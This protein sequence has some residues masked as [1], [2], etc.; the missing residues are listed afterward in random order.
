MKNERTFRF[1]LQEPSSGDRVVVDSN[2]QTFSEAV[3]AAYI[4]QKELM[5]LTCKNY[6]IVG[7]VELDAAMVLFEELEGLTSR[8]SISSLL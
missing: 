8:G 5:H 4:K 1:I 2:T 7:A 6:H 3:P